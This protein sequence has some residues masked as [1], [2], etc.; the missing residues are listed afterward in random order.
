MGFVVSIRT[1]LYLIV[2]NF[3]SQ[4][5]PGMFEQNDLNLKKK[6]SK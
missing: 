5:K 1:L 3:Y 6:E 4:I 2:Y